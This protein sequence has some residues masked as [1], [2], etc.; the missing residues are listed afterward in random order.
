MSLYTRC[1]LGFFL[2]AGLGVLMVLFAWG[3]MDPVYAPYYGV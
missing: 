3:V 2:G 1:T